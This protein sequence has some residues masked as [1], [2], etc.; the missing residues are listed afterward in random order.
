MTPVQ[1]EGSAAI[2][3]LVDTGATGTL[4]LSTEAARNAG[5]LAPGRTVSRARSVSL[6]GVSLD[7]MVRARTVEAAGLTLRSVDV[8]VY[9]PSARGPI[10]QGLLGTGLLRRHRVALDLDGG[11]LLLIPAGPTLVR[12]PRS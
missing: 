3:V 2:D 1:V 9:A 12:E 4:A 10:P 5:L 7:R 8:Q 6:G 11:R